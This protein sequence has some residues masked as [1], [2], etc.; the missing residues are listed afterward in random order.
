[1]LK[2]FTTE[3]AKRLEMVEISQKSSHIAKILA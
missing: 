3:V 1:M 2:K